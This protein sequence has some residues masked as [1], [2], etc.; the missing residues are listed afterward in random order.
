MRR[1][2]NYGLNEE[3]NNLKEENQAEKFEANSSH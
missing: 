2:K 1:L 3:T